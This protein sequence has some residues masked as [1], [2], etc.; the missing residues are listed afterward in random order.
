VT[1]SIVLIVF[2]TCKYQVPKATK[3][4]LKT[5]FHAQKKNKRNSFILTVA[6]LIFQEKNLYTFSTRLYTTLNSRLLML[7][8]VKFYNKL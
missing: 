4:E 6:T 3:Y 8:T 2:D 7:Y 5:D 1:I